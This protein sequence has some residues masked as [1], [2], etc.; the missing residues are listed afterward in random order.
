MGILHPLRPDKSGIMEVDFSGKCDVMLA[1]LTL[2][3]LVRVLVR[4]D[5]VARF[6][7]ANHS[8]MPIASLTAFGSPTADR[9]AAHRKLDR[10]RVYLYAGGLRK[11]A[12][13]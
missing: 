1:K 13:S 6:V 8:I 12:V 2:L 7:N 10:R 5:N 3:E 11:R 9:M 4:L